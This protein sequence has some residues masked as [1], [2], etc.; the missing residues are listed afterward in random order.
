LLPLGIWFFQQ[1]SLVAPFGNA[2][3]IPWVTLVVTPLALLSAAV[4][5]LAPDLLP[6]CL[7]LAEPTARFTLWVLAWLAD[8]PGANHAISAP[9]LPAL[10]LALL[11]AGAM[12]L[13]RGIAVRALGAL[14]IVPLLVAPRTAPAPGAFELAVVD[15]G[16][17]LSVLVRTAHHDLLY[18]AGPAMPNGLDFGEA[19]V[20]PALTAFGVSSL[21]RLVIS[22]RDNDHAGGAASVVRRLH[23]AQVERSD[24]AGGP[25]CIAGESWDWDGVRFE[26]LHPPKDFPYLGNASCCVLKISAGSHA[27]LLPGDIQELTEARLAREQPA[28]IAAELLVAPHHGSRGSS[29]PAFLA[30]TKPQQVLIS[31]GYRSR[32]GH[33]HAET[34][35]RYGAAG[36]HW[37]NTAEFG[38]LRVMVAPTGISEPLGFR[39]QYPRYYREAPL[40]TQ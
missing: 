13:P 24:A 26:F 40:V 3:A 11:G 7:K 20:A 10:L 17:G 31:A 32:F 14:L 29:S 38:M 15:V 9:S 21:D 16:Q 25:T 12:L 6:W 22:H 35:E 8:L 30:A 23:P 18:D 4:F 19:V 27:A 33:P 5:G 28:A 2:F 34:L 39:A 36:A 37:W 1:A